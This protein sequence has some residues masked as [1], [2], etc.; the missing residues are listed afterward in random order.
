MA[1]PQLV[2][3]NCLLKIIE[4]FCILNF[5]PDYKITNK[6]DPF[7]LSLKFMLIFYVHENS[8]TDTQVLLLQN[9][10][11]FQPDGGGRSEQRMGV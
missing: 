3:I 11:V 4:K 6:N 7:L 5:F 8:V 10:L 1:F 9:W 2:L